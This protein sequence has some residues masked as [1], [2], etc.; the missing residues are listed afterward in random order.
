MIECVEGA[1]VKA[2]GEDRGRK[3]SNPCFQQLRPQPSERVYKTITLS[4]VG[5]S[6]YAQIRPLR[7]K[8]DR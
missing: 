2:I 1:V 5:M 3:F 6:K 7:I 8:E 4:T